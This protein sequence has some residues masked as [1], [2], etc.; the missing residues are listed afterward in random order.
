M[1][2]GKELARLEQFVDKLLTNYNV[3]KKECDG[4]Q[5]RLQDREKENKQLLEQVDGLRSDK[6]DMHSRVTGLIGKIEE[7]EK[8]QSRKNDNG[9]SAKSAS[10]GNGSGETMS[11]FS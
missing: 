10:A 9:T 4:L 11:I 6:S 3:L 5:K 7:W 8:S 1:D 2:Q